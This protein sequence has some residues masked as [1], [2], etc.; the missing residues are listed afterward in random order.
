M[1]GWKDVVGQNKGGVHGVQ[2]LYLSENQFSRISKYFLEKASKRYFE[3]LEPVLIRKLC[4]IQRGL[5]E[6]PR[7]DQ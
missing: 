6:H 7:G 1:A 3:I 4:C 2:Q 5:Y